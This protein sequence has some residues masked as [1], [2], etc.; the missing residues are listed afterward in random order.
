M[1]C[2]QRQKTDVE[3]DRAYAAALLRDT[4]SVTPCPE[5]GE[6]VVAVEELGRESMIV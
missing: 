2:A 3:I 1:S 6:L 5:F 4:V